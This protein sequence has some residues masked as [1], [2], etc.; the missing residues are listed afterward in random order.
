MTELLSLGFHCEEMLKTQLFG[1]P[2]IEKGVL[3][4]FY[5]ILATKM[6]EDG[7]ATGVVPGPAIEAETAQSK[8]E[9]F[10]QKNPIAKQV[11]THKHLD[12]VAY[13]K[14]HLLLSST[15]S[16]KE[17]HKKSRCL[18]LFART[19]RLRQRAIFC[20]ISDKRTDSKYE[21]TCF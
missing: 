15:K 21:G 1:Y 7:F 11:R 9:S 16:T 5:S 6:V 4:K 18:L 13:S 14:G 19:V 2:K 10:I 8:F 20:A 12:V 3:N 17:R